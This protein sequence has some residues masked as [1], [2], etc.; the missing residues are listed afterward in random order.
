VDL[1]LE[2]YELAMNRNPR[3]D[4][5]H[6]IEHATLTK[7]ASTQRAADLGVQIST[8]PQFVRF[9]KGIDENL[10]AER[11]G[12]IMVTR[13]WLE[14]GINVALGSDTPTS[15]WYKPQ[16][17]LF[18]AVTRLG[19]DD[20]PFHPEQAMTMEEALYAHTMGSAHAAF[21]EEVK[22]SLEVGKVADLVVW[23]DDFRRAAPREILGVEA[24]M[25]FI[26]GRRL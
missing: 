6:R 7:A 12:R 16:V 17:T 10:G 25:T 24:E 4:P 13:E 14:A 22:G 1:V 26:N 3:P 2:A 23:S 19:Y 9:S 20:Q 5:R 15:P 11:A 8:Q 21:E 18:G